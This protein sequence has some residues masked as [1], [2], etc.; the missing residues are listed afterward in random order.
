MVYRMVAKDTVEEAI[1]ALQQRKRA[2]ADQALG[3]AD[4]ASALTREDLL[5]LL[6]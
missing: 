3:E 1:L 6:R 4:Q 2:I 5:M